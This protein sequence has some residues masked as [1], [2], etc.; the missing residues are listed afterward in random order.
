MHGLL[1]MYCIVDL[2]LGMIQVELVRHELG[3]LCRSQLFLL[4]HPGLY[5]KYQYL[6]GLLSRVS[7]YRYIVMPPREEEAE[8]IHNV[9]FLEDLI[10]LHE[11]YR[12]SID[13]IIE[14]DI[15]R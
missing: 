12:C 14:K 1:L 11:G 2:Y 10:G 5:I 15:C 13:R 8:S 9:I 4:I 7:A 6:C 3:F